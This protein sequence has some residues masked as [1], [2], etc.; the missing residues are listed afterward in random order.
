MCCFPGAAAAEALLTTDWRIVTALDS[1]TSEIQHEFAQAP[2]K[3]EAKSCYKGNPQEPV[4]YL[5]IPTYRL[6]NTGLDDCISDL[7]AFILYII[8]QQYSG[9]FRFFGGLDL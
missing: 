4:T 5:W 7:Q 1:S 8:G 2:G 9:T 6:G 3:K